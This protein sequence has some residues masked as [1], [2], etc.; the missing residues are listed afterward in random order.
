MK[1]YEY[2]QTSPL[3]RFISN[4][5]NVMQTKGWEFVTFQLE[6]DGMDEDCAIVLYRRET[7]TIL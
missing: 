3:R 1:N 7:T 6:T 4:D 2:T 5:I